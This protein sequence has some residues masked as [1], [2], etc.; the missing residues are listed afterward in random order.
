MSSPKPDPF[1]I[2]MILSGREDRW[3]ERDDLFMPIQLAA[4]QAIADGCITPQR[5]AALADVVRADE[6][7]CSLFPNNALLMGIEA[8]LAN[9]TPEAEHD[10]LV[11][12]FAGYVEENGWDS[13]AERVLKL[14]L[15]LFGDIY[16]LLFDEPSEPVPLYLKICDFT[17]AFACGPRRKCFEIVAKAHGAASEGGFGTD[18]LFVAEKFV[19]ARIA[20]SAVC[21][22]AKYRL[23]FGKPKIYAERHFPVPVE[24]ATS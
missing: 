12:I 14:S 10:L 4:G 1:L 5:A 13:E 8:A 20:S 18:Y 17:G 22:A 15:P 3:A 9:W 7:A 11:F 21:H 24:A 23:R 2:E 16:P 19:Q 6:R